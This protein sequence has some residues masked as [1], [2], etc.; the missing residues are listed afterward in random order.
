MFNIRL[1]TIVCL[2]TLAFAAASGCA[3]KQVGADQQQETSSTTQQ[4][5][6]GDDAA[7]KARQAEME[8]IRQQELEEQRAREA[9]MVMAKKAIANM[10]FFDFDSSA[11]KPE[12]REVLQAKAEAMELLPEVTLVIEGHCDDRGT[13]EYNL[14]L[15]ERRARAAY[16]YLVRLGVAPSRL[17]I[18]SYGEERPMVMGSGESAWAKNRRCEF[19]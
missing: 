14:A 3:K 7:E 9:A 15:G 18:V 4:A 13:D 2:L 5:T 6:N 1:I 19:K 11:L 16:E 8:R 17:S 12:S 10:I